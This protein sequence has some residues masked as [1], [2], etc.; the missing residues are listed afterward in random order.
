MTGWKTGLEIGG[1]FFTAKAAVSAN[2]E[3]S[4]HFGLGWL[5]LML[6]PIILRVMTT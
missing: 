3:I 1:F 6:S 5:D 2:L 4:C